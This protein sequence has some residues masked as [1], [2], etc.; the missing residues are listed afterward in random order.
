[1]IGLEH[2]LTVAGTLFVCGTI[3]LVLNPKV[4]ALPLLVSERCG[5]HKGGEL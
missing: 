5:F 4:L 2:Y 3:G 1:M